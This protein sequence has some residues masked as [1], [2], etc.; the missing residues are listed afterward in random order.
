MSN[1]TRIYR[2]CTGREIKPGDILK[3]FHFKD[4][5]T[6]RKIHMYKLV[7]R[8]DNGLNICP[9]GEYLYAVDIQDI[10]TCNSLLS[11]HKFYL[12]AIEDFS[13]IEIVAGGSV[14]DND[15]FWERP[16]KILQNVG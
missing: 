9:N 6:R 1:S 10:F 12:G 15:L 4:Y 3:V 11:A 13:D 7:C 2:D 5:R 8:A 14:K 16:R